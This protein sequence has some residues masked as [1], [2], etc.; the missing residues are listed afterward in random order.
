M[1]RSQ[2]IDSEDYVFDGRVWVEAD[3][4]SASDAVRRIKRNPFW[5]NRLQDKCEE[6]LT[7][8]GWFG[9]SEKRAEGFYCSPHQVEHDHWA[10][11]FETALP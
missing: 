8:C 5:E 7:V 9:C 11:G 4:M 6:Q 1:N 10:A 3:N 2:E